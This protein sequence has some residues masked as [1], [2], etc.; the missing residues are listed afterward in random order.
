MK[1]LELKGND[2]EIGKKIG[3]TYQKYL[4]DLVKKNKD[5]ILDHQKELI[6]LKRFI[7]K[8]YPNI[9]N[10]ILGR[11]DGARI[12]IEEMIYILSPEFSFKE[13]GCTTI[14]IKDNNK[15]IYFSH[16]EDEF[17]FKKDNTFLAIYNYDDYSLI[18]YITP[19]LLLGSTFTI[20][21]YGLLFSSNYL[22]PNEINKNNISRYILER[23][24]IDCKSI[25]EVKRKLK[26]ID[27]A[28]PFSF[29]VVDT[30]KKIAYNFEKD[31]DKLYEYELKDR[32]A[33]ANHFILKKG[34]IKSS[35]SSS[36]RQLKTK[37]LVKKLDKKKLTLNK[38]L[39]IMNYQTKDY[40]KSIFLKPGRLKNSKT[41][42]NISYSSKDDIVYIKDYL[43][44]KEIKIEIVDYK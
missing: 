40:Y 30:K 22:F 39:K 28:S 18:G 15:D 27:V 21:S 13:D 26:S 38:L 2:Y 44:N 8:D 14:M 43:S 16:N 34:K 4:K 41:V 23:Y 11:S 25:S 29:N 19:D 12:N 24:L 10:E 17:D 32:Y 37:E 6:K 3:K 31:L 7:K 1:I 33:R 36:F 9:Y 35:K 42:A 20:N 5:K